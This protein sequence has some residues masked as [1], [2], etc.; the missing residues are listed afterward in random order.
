[1]IKKAIIKTIVFFDL[2]DHPLTAWEVWQYGSFKGK[3][4]FAEILAELEAGGL[5]A[6]IS[7]KQ[8]FYF[9]AGRE[10]LVEKRKARYMIADRKVKR[11]IKVV[12]LIR[13]VPW[14]ELAA[15]SN[16]IGSHNMKDESDIDLFIVATDGRVWL[17]R[18]FCATLVKLLRLRPAEGRTRDTICLNFYVCRS[19]ACLKSLMLSDDPYFI[20]WLAGLIPIYER[21]GAYGKLIS[22]NE[23]LY[24]FLPNWRPQELIGYHRVSGRPSR[25]WVGVAGLLFGW[26]ERPLKR[27]QLEILPPELKSK[28]N[29]STDVVINDAV[30]KLHSK[31]R[32]LEYLEKFN[33]HPHAEA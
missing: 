14:I 30:I 3:T 7:Q 21:G 22:A 12:R 18:F 1:M 29:R 8:G 20:Y 16:I 9:L 11:A 13:L 25:L 32:R 33:S 6:K 19:E 24:G 31:D 28:M 2:F 23:W 15:I 10:D 27:F 26:L 4:E 17:T 5:S